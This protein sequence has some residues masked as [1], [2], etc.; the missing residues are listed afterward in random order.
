M[1]SQKAIQEI[2]TLKARYPN[3]R[4]ALMPALWIAQEENGY[5]SKD[6]LREVADVMGLTPADVESVASF[7]S[8]YN[9]QP[10]GKYMVEVCTNIACSLLGGQELA[11]HIEQRLGVPIGENTPDGLFTV[12]RVEC[13]ASCGGAPAIQVNGLY[14]ENM[15]PERFD[16]LVEELRG[17]ENS[18]RR[19][20][21][22]EKGD[23]E[24]SDSESDC[25]PSSFRPVGLCISVSPC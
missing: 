6:T 2:E 20:G 21:D 9:K 15:T 1:L 16:T 4:S 11:R 10:V 14:H 3:F 7:Y 13:M 22:T 18:T 12:K 8:M 19:H 5:L 23:R 25:C 17:K 24:V